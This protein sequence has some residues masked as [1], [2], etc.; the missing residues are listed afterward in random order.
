MHDKETPVEALPIYNNNT[1]APEPEPMTYPLMR[2]EVILE[3][4]LQFE[5]YNFT[6]N[7][8][9]NHKLYYW[10]IKN[11]TN[12]VINEIIIYDKVIYD[13]GITTTP[14]KVISLGSQ[15]YQTKDPL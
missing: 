15:F 5:Q 8:T 9:F 2:N 12:A 3:Q 10:V 14:Y 4:Y 6:Y 1:Y 13:Y 11:I 7:A